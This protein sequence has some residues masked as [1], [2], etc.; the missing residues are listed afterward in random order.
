M[1]FLDQPLSAA[2]K[3]NKKKLQKKAAAAAKNAPQQDDQSDL[4]E[5]KEKLKERLQQAKDEKVGSQT[6]EKHC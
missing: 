5:L 4:I 1:Y 3:K 6:G 2:A